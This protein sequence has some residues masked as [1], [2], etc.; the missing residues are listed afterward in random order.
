[1]KRAIVFAAMGIGLAFAASTAHAQDITD[2]PYLNNIDVNSAGYTGDWN[3]V[4]VTNV[5]DIATG[6]E[7]QVNNGMN[8][9]GGENPN[10]FSQ[11]YSYIPSVQEVTPNTPVTGS[12]ITFTW[13]SGNAVAGINLLYA[14]DDS[15]GGTDYYDATPGYDLTPVAGQTYSYYVPLSAP[16]LVNLNTPGNVVNGFNLQLDPANVY[17]PYDITINS[18]ALVPEPASIGMGAISFAFLAFRRRR[19]AIATA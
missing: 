2:S 13:N 3:N 6:L 10:N 19:K 16:N 11:F 14:L 8:N 7:F 18:I 1:M 5:Q 17:G 15:A 9:S 12:V 4:S